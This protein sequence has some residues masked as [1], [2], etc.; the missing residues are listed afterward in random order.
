MIRLYFNRHSYR[1]TQPPGFS[2]RLVLLP[3]I[4]GECGLFP[5]EKLLQRF[6]WSD[7]WSRC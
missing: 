1:G 2:R 6:L 7:C 4:R 5:L 3:S